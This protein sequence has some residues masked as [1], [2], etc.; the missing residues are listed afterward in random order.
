MQ[1]TL[2]DYLEHGQ[3]KPE[4]K[5]RLLPKFQFYEDLTAKIRYAQRSVRVCARVYVYSYEHENT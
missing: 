1:K 3:A 4:T 5:Q 2:T